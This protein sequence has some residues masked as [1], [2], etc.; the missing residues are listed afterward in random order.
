MTSGRNPQVHLV[1]LG[2]H[3]S[4]IILGSCMATR[5]ILMSPTE[6]RVKVVGAGGESVNMN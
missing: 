1:H 2:T 4:K 6:G 3:S 5:S